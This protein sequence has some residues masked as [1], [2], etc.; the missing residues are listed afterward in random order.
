MMTIP[1]RLPPP[2][3]LAL[4]LTCVLSM[5]MHCTGD[6]EWNSL[7]LEEGRPG[8]APQWTPD[9]EQIAFSFGTYGNADTY[10]ASSDGSRLRKLSDYGE[11]Q[12]KYQLDHSPDISP[13]GSRV[14]YA[15]TRH[16]VNRDRGEETGIYVHNFEIETSKLD[17]SDRRRLTLHQLHDQLPVWSPDGS[18][19]A[20]VR[21]YKRS[22]RR[23]HTSYGIHTMSSDG[24]DQ[25]MVFA[26]PPDAE[27]DEQTAYDLSGTG[28]VSW[29]PDGSS[30]AFSV[31]ESSQ[32]VLYTVGADGTGPRRLYAEGARSSQ[33]MG[34]EVQEIR[35]VPAWSPDGE[36]IAFLVSRIGSLT[37]YTIAPDGTDLREVTLD[38][39]ST[40]ATEDP[41]LS[42]SPD[43]R[44][45]L[46]SLGRAP[47]GTPRP[48]PYRERQEHYYE[49]PVYVVDVV[50][51]KPSHPPRE[52]GSGDN[53]SWSPDGSRIA[54]VA[55]APQGNE[56][57]LYTVG[58]DGSDRRVLVTKHGERGSEL[59][60]AGGLVRAI[61]A[62]V[63]TKGAIPLIVAAVIAIL[64]A[65]CL[66]IILRPWWSRYEWG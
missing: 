39:N 61:L 46:F 31:Y 62:T 15:T 24:S 26:A 40:R 7:I 17:G 21:A 66:V 53:A 59:K 27:G 32:S 1:R 45:L 49:G 52:I 22:A 2:A 4:V 55:H 48:A 12:E 11:D 37:A 36:R 18:R 58:S 41:S 30:L 5:G 14:V 23:H 6:S 34:N 19:I 64:G 60:S 10:V 54:I 25:R 38:A 3:A 57:F 16:R 63:L 8:L 65:I 47:T 33:G 50:G 35:G 51:G 29:S 13:D 28:G 42:W 9:G 56:D 43:G 44:K 20:F